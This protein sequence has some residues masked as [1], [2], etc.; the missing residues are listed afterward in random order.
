MS[1]SIALAIC[2]SHRESVARR[3]VLPARRAKSW[4]GNG[5]NPT[6]ATSNVPGGATL[7]SSAQSHGPPCETRKRMITTMPLSFLIAQWP[8]GAVAA[9]WALR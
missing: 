3:R 7:Q 4:L 6:R 2:A 9:A 1:R 5:S 8:S